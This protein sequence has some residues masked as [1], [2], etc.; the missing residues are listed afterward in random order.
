L[1]VGLLTTCLA[2]RREMSGSPQSATTAERGSG[3]AQFGL[4]PLLVIVAAVGVLLLA[5]RGADAISPAVLP[6]VVAAVGYIL[7]AIG[8]ALQA[9]LSWLAGSWPQG[10][11]PPAPPV[12]TPPPGSA[13]RLS[14]PSIRVP[15]WLSTL[16]IWISMAAA[17]LFSVLLVRF[18]RRLP[19]PPVDESGRPIPGRTDEPL[20]VLAQG[21]ARMVALLARLLQ[22]LFGSRRARATRPKVG[23]AQAPE[24]ERSLLSVRVAY[25]VFLRWAAERGY[26][27]QPH[28]TPDE[29]R[30][31]LAVIRP[32]TRAEVKLITSLYVAARY[33][34]EECPP[35]ELRRVQAALERLPSD[36]PGNGAPGASPAERPPTA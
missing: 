31:R 12:P 21:P 2:R 4:A 25:C 24:A 34:S 6:P 16:M 1:A 11:F 23:A 20:P 35:A 27:R 14:P 7:A 32:D 29:L 36:S 9:L 13:E 30:Q 18:I 5:A 22:A 33:G 10:M 19:G 28:E 26:G 15:E 17:L 8:A 3:R